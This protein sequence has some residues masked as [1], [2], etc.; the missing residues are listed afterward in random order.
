MLRDD[1][2]PGAA[3]QSSQDND[4]DDDVVGVAEQWD[5]VGDQVD[6]RGQVGGNQ[7]EGEPM[8]AGDVAVASEAADEAGRVGDQPERFPQIDARRL[9]DDE[10]ADEDDPSGGD[11]RRRSEDRQLQLVG[12]PAAARL[13]RIAAATRGFSTLRP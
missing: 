6:G 13:S 8:P 10:P 11:G 3:D 5:E 12:Q 4:H 7:P 2:R 1:G 9:A